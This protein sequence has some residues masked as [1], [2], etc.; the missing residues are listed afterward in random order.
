LPLG[1]RERRG[2]K[3]GRGADIGVDEAQPFGIGL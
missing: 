2:E 3:I 1:G